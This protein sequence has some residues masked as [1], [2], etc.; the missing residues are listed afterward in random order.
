VLVGEVVRVKHP[1][2]FQ[3]FSI[4]HALA[5]FSVELLALVLVEAQGVLVLLLH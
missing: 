4:P 5:Y 1:V 3:L 2:K